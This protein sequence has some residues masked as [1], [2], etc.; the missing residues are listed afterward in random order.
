MEDDHRSA[1]LTIEDAAERVNRSTT[2]IYAWIRDEHLGSSASAR[3]GREVAG[4][5]KAPLL[6]VDGFMRM[7]RGRQ[8]KIGL[9]PPFTRRSSRNTAS[10]YRMDLLAAV[11]SACTSIADSE[12]ASSS[13]GI[14]IF[15]DSG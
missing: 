4:V 9:T 15:D 14:L 5:M 10:A 11:R 8:T 7:R 6:D 13:L 2:T 12:P 1:W 3:D